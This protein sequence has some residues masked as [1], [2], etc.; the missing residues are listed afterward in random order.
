M[1]DEK[2]KDRNYRL[3]DPNRRSTGTNTK[4]SNK[5]AMDGAAL[6]D[7]DLEGVRERADYIRTPKR[8][9]NKAKSGLSQPAQRLTRLRHVAEELQEVEGMDPRMLETMQQADLYRRRRI[10]ELQRAHGY[11]SAGVSG[12][13]AS[14]AMDLAISR[15]LANLGAS[16]GDLGL[17]IK[18][19]AH[20]Q[21]SAKNEGLAW[22]LCA[23]ESKARAAM[24]SGNDNPWE[25]GGRSKKE[26]ALG[27]SAKHILEVTA[28]LDL[29]K[30]DDEDSDDGDTEC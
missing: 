23:R 16:T 28:P 26:R 3:A 14:S 13:I 10:T 22:E 12:M 27:K 15:Y 2:Q 29:S 30:D 8:R 1:S 5:N 6:S 18:S 7:A 9:G 21:A 11:V 4:G 24:N 17:F 25:V 20:A 19:R